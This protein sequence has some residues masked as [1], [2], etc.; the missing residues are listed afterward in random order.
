MSIFKSKSAIREARDQLFL[1]SADGRRLTTV[2][3]NIGFTRPSFGFSN[4]DDWRALAKNLALDRKNIEKAFRKILEICVGPQFDRTAVIST[5]VDAGDTVVE[6]EDAS[7]LIQTGKMVLSPGLA[8]E[9]EIEFCFVDYVTNK[10]YLVKE[11]ANA[12]VVLPTSEAVLVS[13]VAAA[14]TSLPLTDTSD[15]PTTGYPYP[16]SIGKGTENEETVTVTN[17]DTGTNT[18]TTS[19]TTNAHSGFRA[20]F[21]RR[22]TLDATTA[23]RVFLKFDINDTQDLPEAGWIR[24]DAGLGTEE[25]VYYDEN[26]LDEDILYLK[27][28]LQYGHA[29]GASVELLNKGAEVSVAS[30][31]QRGIHW[32][33]YDTTRDN[34]KVLIPEL[35]ETLRILDGSWLHDTVPSPTGSTTIAVATTATDTEIELASVANFPDEAGMLTID[36]SLRFFYTLR[37]EDATPNPKLVLTEPI[38]AVYA[39]GTAVTLYEV[40]YASTRL[41]EGNPRDQVGTVIPDR[42]PGPYVYDVSARAPKTVSSTITTLHPPAAEMQSDLLVGRETVECD[43]LSLWQDLV[44]PISVRLGSGSGFDELL[45]ATDVTLAKNVN[46]NT[47]MING[48]PIIG[49]TSIVVDHGPLTPPEENFPETVGLNTASF[50]VLIDS[51][52]TDEIIE[53]INVEVGVPGANQTTLTLANPGLVNNYGGGQTVELV[54]DVLTVDSTDNPHFGPTI[55][56]NVAGHAVEF[57]TDTISLTS[58]TG[59]STVGGYVYLNFGKNR[60]NHRTRL[61]AIIGPTVYQFDDTSRFPTTDFPYQITLSEGTAVE[62]L[63]NVT[64]NDTGLNQLTFDAAPVYTH[65]TGPAGFGGYA[66]FNTGDMELIEYQDIDGDDI[67]LNPPQALGKHTIG[68]LIVGAGE[69]SVPRV[70]GYSYPFYLPPDILTCIETMF[71]LVR[72]AGIQVTIIT[73]ED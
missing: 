40:P 31:V 72:A 4:D 7:E 36:G 3:D 32:Y 69:F 48:T 19:A 73:L 44:P 33:I 70:D 17:N 56:P 24:L 5:A 37:D 43:D 38:G 41:E 53:V 57:L 18:L 71:D 10:V 11:T 34:V 35:L 9:E 66:A 23:G 55:S 6:V 29:A 52:G 15:M 46:S 25:V 50:S 42:Y 28:P 60:L 65:S 21:I 27:S 61:N 26:S 8:E 39:P 1:D 63:V 14:A 58:A 45:T 20:D 47:P 22:V 54:H 64:A 12:H 62:E 2:T 13:D 30:M 68:E 67:I 16:V 51:G 59:F 49:D